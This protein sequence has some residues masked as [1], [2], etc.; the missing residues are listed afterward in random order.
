MQRA[1]GSPE[2][3]QLVRLAL[4]RPARQACLAA[5]GSPGLPCGGR[6]ARLALRWQ[7]Y[8]KLQLHAAGER[9]LA[10]QHSQKL[11]INCEISD[12][13]LSLSTSP[14][15]N[16]RELPLGGYPMDVG[17]SHKVRNSCQ[18]AEGGRLARRRPAR[19][20]RLE[21]AG[22]PEGGQLA[23]RVLRRPA[24]PKAASSPGLPCGG[25]LARRRPARQACLEVAA[26]QKTAA[27][28]CW[29]EMSCSPTHTQP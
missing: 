21:A 22:S 16:W 29:R 9:C 25:R 14:V 5:A 7:L 26:L 19:Q 13:S 10:R 15:Q 11:E 6:L 18:S 24:R 2:G 3:G 17:R 27:T 12:W 8:R 1:A 4:R 20:A 28:C 23:R